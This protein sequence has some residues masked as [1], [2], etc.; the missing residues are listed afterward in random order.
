[1]SW[2]ERLFVGCLAFACVDLPPKL[3]GKLLLAFIG[4]FF[5]LRAAG[6]LAGVEPKDGSKP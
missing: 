6:H 4:I 1:V 3:G 2:Y 5:F